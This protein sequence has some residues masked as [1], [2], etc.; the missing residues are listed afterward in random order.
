MIDGK[1]VHSVA[2]SKTEQS[3]HVGD[4]AQSTKGAR[5]GEKVRSTT[6]GIR[7]GKKEQ[8]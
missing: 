8:P 2:V 5:Y 3:M 1:G 6:A 7:Y 4:Q